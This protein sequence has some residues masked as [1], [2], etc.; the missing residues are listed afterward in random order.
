MNTGSEK[1]FK[2]ADRRSVHDERFNVF[3]RAQIAEKNNSLDLGLI[4]DDSLVDAT[5]LPDPIE[6]GEDALDDLQE[7]V[8]LL[9][10]VVN[11]LRTLEARQ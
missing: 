9:Q 3:T 1:A 7:A 11:K 5:E 6:L 2:A 4:R 10:G 8:D